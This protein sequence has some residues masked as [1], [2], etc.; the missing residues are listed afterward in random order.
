MLP[1]E[2]ERQNNIFPD[3]ERIQQIKILEHKTQVISPEVRE[4][5]LVH[6]GDIVRSVKNVPACYGVDGGED[7]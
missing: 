2:G 4:L 7:I 5:I 6:D 3:S 1:L